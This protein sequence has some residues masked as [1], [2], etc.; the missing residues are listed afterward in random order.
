MGAR[1]GCAPARR[2]RSWPGRWG[3]S[4]RTQGRPRS[5]A[6][7]GA[8]G[9]LCGLPPHSR[10]P[11]SGRIPH[12]QRAGPGPGSGH[13]SG[14]SGPLPRLTTLRTARTQK[15]G[16]RCRGATRA[17]RQAQAQE[18]DGEGRPASR[19]SAACVVG[20]QGMRCRAEC[21]P[22][23]APGRAV[24]RRR[25]PRTSGP[26]RRGRGWW[27]APPRRSCGHSGADGRGKTRGGTCCR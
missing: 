19:R 27:H 25:R 21:G 3:R 5:D 26:C 1:S 8:R 15:R 20:L 4:C 12:G 18:Y 13:R 6:G 7:S 22:H 17:Q 16:A 10:T 14:G 23:P 11:R 9:T 24:R 2:G